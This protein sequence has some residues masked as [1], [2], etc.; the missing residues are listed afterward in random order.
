MLL[1]IY[2]LPLV[3]GLKAN[4]N[5]ETQRPLHLSLLQTRTLPQNEELKI[6]YSNSQKLS[7]LNSNSKIITNKNFSLPCPQKV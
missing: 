2:P 1:Q 7:L 4:H 3:E 5:E 6:L